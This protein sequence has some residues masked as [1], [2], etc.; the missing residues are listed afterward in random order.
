MISYEVYKLL[1]I[2]GALFLMMAFGGVVMHAANGGTR[3][4]NSARKLAVITHGVGL[5]VLLVSG[6]GMLARLGIGHAGGFPLWVFLKGGVWLSLGGLLV[7][8]QRAPQLAR[9]FWFLMPVLG[10]LAAFFALTKTGT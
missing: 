6:F 9:V 2:L 5:L 3:E 1:H 7:A 8:A 10:G 4:S